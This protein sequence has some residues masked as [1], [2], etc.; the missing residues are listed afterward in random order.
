MAPNPRRPHALVPA[1]ETV[2]MPQYL[3]SVWLDEPYDDPDL[4]HTRERSAW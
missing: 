1:K 4:S 2:T 3:L